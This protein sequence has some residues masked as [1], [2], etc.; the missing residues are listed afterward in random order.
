MLKPIG[1]G[2]NGNPAMSYN[3]SGNGCDQAQAETFASRLF[4]FYHTQELAA[5]PA[6]FMTGVIEL[7][8]RY[9]ASIVAQAASP[10]WGIPAKH[11]FPPRISEIKEY[12]DAATPQ[13]PPRRYPVLPPSPPLPKFERKP[14][15]KT[16]AEFLLMVERGEAKPRPIGFFESR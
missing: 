16:Y 6:V 1:N 7:F 9:P 10:I 14:E 5:N 11:K 15:H 13:E 8:M 3:T 2:A 12:L 4:D